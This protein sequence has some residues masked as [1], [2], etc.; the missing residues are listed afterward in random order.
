MAKNKMKL[1]SFIGGLVVFSVAVGILIHNN[2]DKALAIK[3]QAKRAVNAT[4][5]TVRQAQETY[6]ERIESLGFDIVSKDNKKLEPTDTESDGN[7]AYDELWEYVESQNDIYV[8][9]HLAR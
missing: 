3:D 4:R 1:V 8:K 2:K 5:N 9:T 6:K 7:Q